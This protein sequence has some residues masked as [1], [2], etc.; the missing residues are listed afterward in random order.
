MN[1]EKEIDNWSETPLNKR[2]AL[3]LEYVRK[4]IKVKSLVL[5]VL[6][7]FVADRNRSVRDGLLSHFAA[8]AKTFKK[9]HSAVEGAKWLVHNWD[10][11][12]LIGT[13][14]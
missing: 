5:W 1:F 9:S 11:G 12:Y 2:Y 8:Y 4:R 3:L 6:F 13:N 10:R 14:G 7:D